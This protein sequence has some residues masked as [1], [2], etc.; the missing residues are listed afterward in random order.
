MLNDH[1]WIRAELVLV[2][3]VSRGAANASAAPLQKSYSMTI[4]CRLP[5]VD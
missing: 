4:P 2:S 5:T 3:D 1:S